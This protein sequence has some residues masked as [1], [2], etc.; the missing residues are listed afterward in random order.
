VSLE[1]TLETIA[2]PDV[3][4]LLSV[5]TKTG[6]LRVEADGK[7]G[8]LWLDGGRVS[9][10]D[11]G[12]NKTPVDAFFALLRLREGTFRF[13]T[14]GRALNPVAPLEVGPVLEEA[15]SRLLEWPA[16]VA[17]V[18]SLGSELALEPAVDDAVVLEP[19]QWR[20]VASVGSGKLVGDVLDECGLGE[21]DGC[22]AVKELVDLK[23]VQVLATGASNPVAAGAGAQVGAR[24]DAHDGYEV[25]DKYEVRD[26]Q[27]VAGT[28]GAQ[29]LHDMHGSP[30]VDGSEEALGAHD[31]DDGD[32]GHDAHDE[33]TGLAP[34]DNGTGYGWQDD[35]QPAAGYGGQVEGDVEA[36]E[37]GSG[38]QEE[39]VPAVDFS[40]DVWREDDEEPEAQPA[41]E[42]QHHGEPVNRGLLLKFLGS[43]R[44]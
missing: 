34:A 6:E 17:V 41:A 11:V 4:A 8:S 19:E 22:K 31:G 29:D 18:P 10:F 7:T 24:L 26:G 37:H 40:D 30:E 32:D 27:D 15:E 42:P 25:P 23:L 9:G 1:G 39:A 44:N 14:D 2:L 33:A 5:T 12:K 3:L 38:G 21:F 13:H 28:E 16:I 43:A 35:L 36:A 20:L